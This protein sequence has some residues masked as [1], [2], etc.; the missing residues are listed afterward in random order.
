MRRT[1]CL[2]A[3]LLALLPLGSLEPR[4]YDGAVAQSDGL[5]GTWEAVDSLGQV[6]TYRDGRFTISWLGNSKSGAYATDLRRN[7]R[8]LD[9][10]PDPDGEGPRVWRM[11]YETDGDTLRVAYQSVG[12]NGERPAGFTDSGIRIITWKR[13]K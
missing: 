13:V 9:E 3:A 6:L 1:L 10:T 5:E 7:P 4:G 2:L 11:I 8:H 12:P